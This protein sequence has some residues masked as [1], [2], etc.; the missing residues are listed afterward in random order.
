[1]SE[2]MIEHRVREWLA[3]NELRDEE[4]KHGSFPLGMVQRFIERA[5]SAEAQ[6][7]ALL[8][9]VEALE[10]VAEAARVLAN[11]MRIDSGVAGMLS[12]TGE[13]AALDAALAALNASEKESE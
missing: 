5:E 10:R 11:R 12:C 13:F 8:A 6:C 1:M 2:E 4:V 3:A 7:A 9:R